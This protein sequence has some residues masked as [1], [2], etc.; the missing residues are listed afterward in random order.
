MRQQAESTAVAK[1]EKEAAAAKAE[2]E[3]A[4]AM[5]KIRSQLHLARARRGSATQRLHA[6]MQAQQWLSEQMSRPKPYDEC[7][8]GSHSVL[9]APNQKRVHVFRL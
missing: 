8:P 1:A 5:S 4:A 6:Q 3:T 7:S 2:N 9:F